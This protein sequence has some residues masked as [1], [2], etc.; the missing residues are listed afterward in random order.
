MARKRVKRD[1]EVVRVI[2]ALDRVAAALL[3]ASCAARGMGP[4]YDGAERD[5]QAVLAA[6]QDA[7][8]AMRCNTLADLVTCDRQAVRTEAQFALAPT[9]PTPTAPDATAMKRAIKALERVCDATQF[10]WEAA[11][12]A[13]AAADA[14][15]IARGATDEDWDPDWFAATEAE[16]V[17]RL[18]Y[19]AAAD[20]LCTA[21]DD[22]RTLAQML[23]C[24]RPAVREAAAPFAPK[25]AP[26]APPAPRR[27]R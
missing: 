27:K 18:A 5:W 19:S 26:S 11:I 1:A 14:A 8:A 13:L 21:S 12:A 20:D 4:A 10:A 23:A 22:C 2:V 6:H 9:P 3:A 7:R 17:A 24:E 15:A 25:L 16:G